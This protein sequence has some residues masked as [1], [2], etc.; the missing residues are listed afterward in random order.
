MAMARRVV[1]RTPLPSTEAVAA[2]LGVSQKRVRELRKL[3]GFDPNGDQN[4]ATK[5]TK[6][7]AS[8]R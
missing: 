5:R 1:I 4:R 3:I 6:K 2:E 8:P 7:R